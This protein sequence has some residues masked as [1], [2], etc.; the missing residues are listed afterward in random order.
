MT[1]QDWWLS[2]HKGQWCFYEHSLPRGG[3]TTLR[4][5][6]GLPGTNV[7]EHSYKGSFGYLSCLPRVPFWY[8]NPCGG[9]GI[10]GKLPPRGAT[11]SCGYVWPQPHSSQSR[12]PTCHL[13]YLPPSKRALLVLESRE[14]SFSTGPTT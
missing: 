14:G 12:T 4:Y 9:V 7:G 8:H 2:S 6:Y 11:S 1:N 3:I 5:H 13:G 10:R